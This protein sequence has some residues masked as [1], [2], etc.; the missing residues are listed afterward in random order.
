MVCFLNVKNVLRKFLPLF[1]ARV[2]ILSQFRDKLVACFC[3]SHGKKKKW[4]RGE[5]VEF[6][7]GRSLTMK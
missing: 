2:L 6:Q 5:K 1:A 7:F 3:Y 4:G